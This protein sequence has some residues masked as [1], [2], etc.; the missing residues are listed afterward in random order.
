MTNPSYH[1]RFADR[2]LFMR[3]Q[4][5]MAVGHRYMRKLDP[6]KR[7]TVPSIPADFDFNTSFPEG[8]LLDGATND[9]MY[10]EPPTDTSDVEDEDD[11]NDS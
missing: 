8:G 10:V 11:R 1:A 7:A 2:D 6:S 9:D 3:Y 4:Y 5:G